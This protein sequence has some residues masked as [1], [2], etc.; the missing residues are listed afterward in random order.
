MLALFEEPASPVKLAKMIDEYDSAKEGV[1]VL[2]TS[3]SNATYF[4]SVK[5]I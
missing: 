1:I 5:L 4:I 2:I 3:Y